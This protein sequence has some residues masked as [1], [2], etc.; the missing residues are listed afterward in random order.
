MLV[1][2]PAYPAA[3]VTRAPM[4]VVLSDKV[5]AKSRLI[6]TDATAGSARSAAIC[7][8]V[9]SVMMTGILVSVWTSCCASAG[10]RCNVCCCV[11]AIRPRLRDAWVASRL[12]A[13]SAMGMRR[14]TMTRS[15]ACAARLGALGDN[16]ARPSIVMMPT[17]RA[18]VLRTRITWLSLSSMLLHIVARTTIEKDHGTCTFVPWSSLLLFVLTNRDESHRSCSGHHRRLC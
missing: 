3:W 9:A 8:L 15:V 13:R 6:C 12:N 1:P 17:K 18:T 16:T 2:A 11:S 14:V 5:G 4:C 10:W 7:S